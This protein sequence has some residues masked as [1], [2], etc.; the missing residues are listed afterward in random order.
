MI[1]SYKHNF[2]FVKSRKTA[3]TSME[4]ALA[5]CCGE[6]DIIT[7]LG[8]D[9]ELLRLKL[10]ANAKPRNYLSDRTI[11]A[12][13]WEYVVAGNQK[14][15]RDVHQN[16]MPE[17]YR[18]YNHASAKRAVKVLGREFWDKAYKFT[19]ERHP[20]E[21]CVSWA[22]HKKRDKSTDE[23]IRHSLDQGMYRN[24]DLY[25]LEGKV[26]VDFIVRYEHMESDVKLLEQKLGMELYSRMP[27]AKGGERKD[28]RPAREV[29]S[30]DHK[31]QIRE[32]CAEEF[33][34]MGY[35]T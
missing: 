10:D 17:T 15:M 19:I 11:E 33:A 23:A 18:L 7:P 25:S 27:R 22:W 14:G 9:D 26:A 32:F 16:E 31:A 34:L 28:P 3:G 30:D 2:I 12:K 6:D 8:S 4:I 35:E 1:V 20:Y 24:F 21:K 5:S 29:L 13:Y